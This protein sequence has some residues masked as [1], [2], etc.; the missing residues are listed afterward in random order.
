MSPRQFRRA[1]PLLILGGTVFSGSGLTG[2]ETID[3]LLGSFV[4]PGR[5]GQDSDGDGFTDAAELAAN[6]DIFDATSTPNN[7]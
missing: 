4:S 1:A 3:N 6:S 5:G 2:C 7:R